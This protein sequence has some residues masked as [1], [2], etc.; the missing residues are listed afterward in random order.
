MDPKWWV[1]I[2]YNNLEAV[3][4]AKVMKAKVRNYYGQRN[5]VVEHTVRF[6]V[7]LTASCTGES[8]IL[9]NQ[10]NL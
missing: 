4:K 8:K 6:C 3:L 10:T 5:D 9:K 2:K 7:C 1:M